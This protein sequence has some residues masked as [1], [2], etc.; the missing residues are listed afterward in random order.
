M[1]SYFSEF[2]NEDKI[3]YNR[4]IDIISISQA[5]NYT[6]FSNFLNPHEQQIAQL[7][8]TETGFSDFCF[9]GGNDMCERKVFVA[10]SSYD[11]AEN[12]DIFP[13]DA[14][15]FLYRQQDNLS[16]RDFLGCFMSKLIKRETIGDI[17]VGDG[18]CVVFALHSVADVIAEIDKI[19]GV[20]VKI[21]RGVEGECPSNFET[22]ELNA[23]VTSFR[24]DCVVSAIA[25]VSREKSSD[26]ISKGHVFI[27]Y[28]E[29]TECSKNINEGDVISVRGYGKF[30]FNAING[31][32]KKGRN[33]I[34]Y[35]KFK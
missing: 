19:G 15:T 4:I 25:G 7:A 31:K 9:F 32:T 33:V 1:R 26:L 5:K 35:S 34:T 11:N 2:S 20:G 14:Y 12:Q 28:E 13:I 8:A 6:K 30:L 3:L 18:K 29:I 16:H 23:I 10:F 27:N 24:A 21:S 17:F 22:E